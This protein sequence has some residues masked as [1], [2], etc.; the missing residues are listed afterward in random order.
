MK[1]RGQLYILSAII[2]CVVLFGLGSRVNTIEKKEVSDISEVSENYAVEGSEVINYGVNKDA[3]IMESFDEFTNN[4]AEYVKGKDPEIGFIYVLAHG[5]STKVRNDLKKE[6]LCGED[7]CIQSCDWGENGGTISIVGATTA[8]D[9]PTECVKE[10]SRGSRLDLELNKV[11]H[12]F[13]TAY[14]NP[15]VGV[16]FSKKEGNNVRIFTNEI[17]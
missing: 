3:A 4:F 17:K 1:K 13:D 11:I 9:I 10:Y 16:L 15:K 8:V 7:F 5:D 2:I 14:G 12:K 6:G